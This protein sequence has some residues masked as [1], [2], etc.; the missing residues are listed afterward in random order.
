MLR[1]PCPCPPQVSRLTMDTDK[2][3]SEG[4]KQAVKDMEEMEQDYQRVCEGGPGTCCCCSVM[5]PPPPPALPFRG[6]KWLG[7]CRGQG[8]APGNTPH[9]ADGPIEKVGNVM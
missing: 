9:G 4:A 3:V 8:A 1:R 7:G 6:P 2:D 5:C